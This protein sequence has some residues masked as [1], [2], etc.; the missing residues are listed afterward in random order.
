[1]ILFPPFQ[2]MSVARQDSG[3]SASQLTGANARVARF[4]SA[5]VSLALASL[6]P[7]CASLSRAPSTCY[8]DDEAR[9]IA[10]RAPAVTSRERPRTET[11]IFATLQLD[12]DRLFE[13]AHGSENM[14]YWATY[15]LSPHY[16]LW[17]T[18]TAFQP[19][20]TYSHAFV[21]SRHPDQRLLSP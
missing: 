5:V 8:T 1:M 15:S 21:R 17:L 10:R 9:V 18:G 16:A 2:K 7:A 6:L 19:W 4:Q 13:P 3:C 14:L 11:Q 12:P 20:G